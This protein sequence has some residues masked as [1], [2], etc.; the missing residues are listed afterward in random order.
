MENAPPIEPSSNSHIDQ[1]VLPDSEELDWDQITYA[2]N[3]KRIL[4]IN[5]YR[6]WLDFHTANS[7][8]AYK[9]MDYSPEE[10]CQRFLQ[11]V[12]SNINDYCLTEDE[13]HLLN[14]L[15]LHPGF[16]RTESGFI[17]LTQTENLTFPCN[18][19]AIE[20]LLANSGALHE[21]NFVAEQVVANDQ[22]V[23]EDFKGQHSVH[24][25]FNFTAEN[26]A[27]LSVILSSDED[28]PNCEVLTTE[29]M[30]KRLKLAKNRFEQ[31]GQ[32]LE[33]V[34]ITIDDLLKKLKAINDLKLAIS[35]LVDKSIRNC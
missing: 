24:R 28:L 21:T 7:E 30:H 9:Y 5:D 33:N 1:I 22:I 25:R 15:D 20:L 31:T 12:L 2:L 6:T 8:N 19:S 4:F 27:L 17:A 35:K 23:I 11:R 32:Q 34:N 14:L 13:Q 18:E 3:Y 26:A 10:L 29:E 16:Q